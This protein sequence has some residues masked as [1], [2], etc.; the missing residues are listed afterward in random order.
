M[1]AL[2]AALVVL[3]WL[4]FTA[5]VMRGDGAGADDPIAA[6]RGWI[7][8][9]LETQLPSADLAAPADNGCRREGI[10]LFV[11]AGQTCVFTVLEGGSR[12]RRGLVRLRQGSG[13]ATF[14][15]APS[16]Q[17]RPGPTSRSLGGE[18][19]LDLAAYAEG[20]TLTLTCTA[21][22]AACRFRLDRPA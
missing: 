12:V 19:V 18:R 22:D 20:G 8:G 5:G 16:E 11:A 13:R 17:T 1:V 10:E 14:T 21:T 3:S 6:A 9:L 7:A 15:P 4:V 2:L